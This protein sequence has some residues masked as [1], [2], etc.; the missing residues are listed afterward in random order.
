VRPGAPPPSPLM[1]SSE[2]DP[3]DDDRVPV[4]GTWRAIYAAVV[5]S[6]LLVMGL[7]ALFSGWPY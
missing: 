1:T 2:P 7:L 6:A 4:F 3:T 5:V